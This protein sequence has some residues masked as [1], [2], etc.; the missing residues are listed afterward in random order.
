MRLIVT[1][2]VLLRVLSVAVTLRLKVGGVSKSMKPLT[3]MMSEEESMAKGK[4]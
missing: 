1:S 2:A 3:M 4:T